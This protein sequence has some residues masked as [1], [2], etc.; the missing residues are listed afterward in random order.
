MSGT[1]DLNPVTS[2]TRRRQ[3]HRKPG[4]REQT[5]LAGSLSPLVTFCAGFARPVWRQPPGRWTA[6]ERA[7]HTT[8]RQDEVIAVHLFAPLKIRDVTFRNRIFLSPMVQFSAT[9]GFASDWHLVHLGTR[10]VGGAA[11]VMTEAAGVEARGRISP[12][13]LGIWSD[14]HVGPFQPVTRFIEQQGAVPAIQLAHAGRKGSR[15]SHAQG[16]GPA[17][18]ASGGWRPVVAPSAIAFDTDYQVPEALD[19]AGIK[20]IVRAFGEAARRAAEAGFRAID[21]HA[22]HGYLLHEFLSPISNH[23]EDRYGGSFENRTRLTR[24]VVQAI[25]TSW[26]ERYPL[27]VR[28]SATDWLDN[29]WDLEQSIELSRQLKPLGVD[30]IDCSS[31]GIAPGA[32]PQG[33]GRSKIDAIGP[34]YQT[35]F[36]ARIRREADILTGAVGLITAP[37]QADHIIRTGQADVVLL[38]RELLR[39]PYWPL[40]A[41]E[42]LGVEGPW[43]VQYLRAKRQ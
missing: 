14:A 37:E 30:L 16:S 36:A 1:S 23:R 21:L 41:A 40:Q 43:P 18:E 4:S 10:A 25:R 32:T 13:D 34:G 35:P 15:A 2:S 31:G 27:L 22:A 42:K 12:Y 11:L 26:P 19:D 28:I 5:Y 3:I 33:S 6:D 20:G 24:E 39:N 7:K 8:G 9:D 17:D 38:G 29:G